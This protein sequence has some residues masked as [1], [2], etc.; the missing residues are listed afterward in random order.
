[1]PTQHNPEE[2]AAGA[3]IW[4]MPAEP[5]AGLLRGIVGELSARFGTPLFE[6]HLTLAGDLHASWG[7]YLPLLDDL[8]KSCAAFSQPIQGIELTEAYFR[9]FYAGF[10]RS[11]ELDTL[12]QICVAQA[13][14][15]ADGFTP[16]I[17]LLYG[18]VEQAEK[19][20]VAKDIEGRLLGKRVDFDRVVVTNSS[21]NVP[22]TEWR[23]HATR[24]LKFPATE[25]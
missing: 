1:M 23:V 17:S 22:I 18:K 9:A 25:R 5:D 20:A 12:K 8:A 16:H 21:D 4:L 7:A 11:A 2:T 19:M 10:T 14:G 6:P 15:T 3:S 24:V 13:G